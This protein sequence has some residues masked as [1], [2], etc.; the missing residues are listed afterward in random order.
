MIYS[1]FNATLFC[2]NCFGAVGFTVL[3]M[4]KS[5]DANEMKTLFSPRHSG[6]KNA[7][8]FYYSCI[9]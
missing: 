1:L 5:I 8:M 7:A 2:I 3:V 4:S 9:H 6:M